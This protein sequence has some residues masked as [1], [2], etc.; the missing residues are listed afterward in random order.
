[1][2]MR[3]H[4]ACLVLVMAGA[5]L[6]QGT[7]PATSAAN[8]IPA[9]DP[10][11]SNNPVLNSVADGGPGAAVTGQASERMVTP[12]GFVVPVPQQSNQQQPQS[13]QPQ[14]GAGGGTQALPGGV[15]Y[16]GYGAAPAAPAGDTSTLSGAGPSVSPGPVVGSGPTVGTGP[17]VGAD[18][19]IR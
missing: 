12:G 11:T 4:A 17:E 3:N 8:S 6:A 19:G 18:A 14:T 16:G 13:S 9:V 5:A 1:M 2:A 10:A 7:A 15:M